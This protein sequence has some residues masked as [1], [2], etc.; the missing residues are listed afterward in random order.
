MLNSE[1]YRVRRQATNTTTDGGKR[2]KPDSERTTKLIKILV[3]TL[4]ALAGIIFILTVVVT[5]TVIWGCQMNRRRREERDLVMRTK[6][7]IFEGVP[8]LA[9]D[10][11]PN[12]P[13]HNK[14][15]TSHSGKY[16]LDDDSVGIDISMSSKL[17]P[18]NN[19]LQVKLDE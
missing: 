7:D 19:N 10:S 9:T 6:Q 8:N 3:G 14:V 17:E 13:I 16:L 2:D 12:S 5:L 18:S 11:L 1:L 4:A 15:D